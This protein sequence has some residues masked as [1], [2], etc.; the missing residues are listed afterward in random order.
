MDS[1][2]VLDRYFFELNAAHFDAFL[3][4]TPLVWNDRLR[5]SAG[6]F[7][8]GRR[9]F[10]K[11]DPPV[12][13]I[14]SYLQKIEDSSKHIRDT[15]AHEMIHYW[16]W[17]RRRPYGHTPEFLAKMREIGAS[18]YNTVGKRRPFKYIY[19]CPHCHREFPSRK[20]LNKLACLPCCKAHSRGRYDPRFRIIFDREINNAASGGASV[21]SAPVQ[22][23]S[24]PPGF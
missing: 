3:E 7:I 9:R 10:F 19:K 8:P 20:K 18:R 6:R 21:F 15:I 14:A 4:K 1:D 12:I 13:E 11:D 5:T 23:H 22:A 16:L 17:A 24:A 2:P